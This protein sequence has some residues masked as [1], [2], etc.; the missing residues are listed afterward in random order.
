[1]R[2]MSAWFICRC[3]TVQWSF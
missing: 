3:R 2:N 1:M